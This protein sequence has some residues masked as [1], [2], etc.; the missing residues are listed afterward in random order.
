MGLH[1]FYFTL[2]FAI[3][4]SP[5]GMASKLADDYLFVPAAVYKGTDDV[6]PSVQPMG[7]LFEQHLF[8]LFDIIIMLLEQKLKVTHE[9]M[10]D[11]HRNIE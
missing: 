10:S 2:I 7:N 3:T 8:M 1:R 4:G 5:S 9:Q 6:I 11:R